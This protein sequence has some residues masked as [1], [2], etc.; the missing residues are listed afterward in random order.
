MVVRAKTLPND[1]ARD[2]AGHVSEAKPNARPRAGVTSFTREYMDYF[3][4]LL[5]ETA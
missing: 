1:P 4:P 5:E 2:P 3:A